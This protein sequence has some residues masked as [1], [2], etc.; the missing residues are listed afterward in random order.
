[1]SPEQRQ[2]LRRKGD[3]FAFSEFAAA[4]GG[5][6]KEAGDPSG[7]MLEAMNPDSQGLPSLLKRGRK[8]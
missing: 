6:A 1:M 5:I 4:G 7:A 3:E 2:E 8:G